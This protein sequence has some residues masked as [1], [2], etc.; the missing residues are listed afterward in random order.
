MSERYVERV[1]LEDGRFA[2]RHRYVDENGNDIEEV[3][4]EPERQLLPAT[5]TVS[6]KREVVVERVIQTLDEHG[7]VVHVETE[8][9]EPKPLQRERVV[10]YVT[11]REDGRNVDWDTPER[12]PVREPVVSTLSLAGFSERIKEKKNWELI[13]LVGLGVVAVA[14]GA[15][16]LGM[17]YF[18]N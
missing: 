10:E 1:F 18:G 17:Q 2:E 9:I 5:R 15:I 16:F 11:K 8:N 4:K 12:E 7:N 13:V 6:K 3:R 14:Q